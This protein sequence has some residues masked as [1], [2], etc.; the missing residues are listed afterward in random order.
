MGIYN[1]EYDDVNYLKEQIKE[2]KERLKE[3]EEQDES[4]FDE[5][6]KWIKGR[7]GNIPLV[8]NHIQFYT[9]RLKELENKG[10]SKWLQREVVEK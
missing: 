2:R 8:K 6:D 7:E 10:L 4:D 5:T 1:K 3:L 9:D